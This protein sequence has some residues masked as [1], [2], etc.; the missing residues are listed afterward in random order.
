MAQ[1]QPADGPSWAG[2]QSKTPC[3]IL[4]H[5]PT[6]HGPRLHLIRPLHSPEI[7]ALLRP[8]GAPAGAP[9]LSPR[10]PVTFPA[11]FY[12]P[13]VP[14]WARSPVPP[15]RIHLPP[16]RSAP[17]WNLIQL[18]LPVTFTTSAALHC[19]LSIFLTL[20]LCSMYF[21]IYLFLYKCIYLGGRCYL[22]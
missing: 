18:T 13:P 12:S 3:P 21:I 5:P 6:P 16:Q 22:G 9:L 8:L 14:Q 20:P 10:P 7:K 11:K 17:A 1:L 4:P 15:L 2:I 19:T